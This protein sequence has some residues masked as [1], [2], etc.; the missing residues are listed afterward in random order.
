MITVKL[1][2]GIRKS[3]LSDTVSI[4]KN[5][6]SVSD[7]LDFLQGLVQ[8]NMPV[9]D[10]RNILVAINGADSSVL[11]GNETLLR[12]G[13]VISIIPVV[14]GGSKTRTNFRISNYHV[15]LIRIGKTSADPVRF[16]ESIRT[17]F[18][19]IVIQ[20]IRSKYILSVN[21][22]KRV[23]EVS[24]AANKAGTLLSNKVETDMLMR[25][26]A[27][28]QISDAISKAGLQK[29]GDS[30]LIAIGRESLVNKLVADLNPMVKPM[31]PF[32]KNANFLKKEFKITKKELDCV[33][34]SE[35]LEDL[36]VERS[37]VLLH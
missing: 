24:L 10:T 2:G 5:S 22:A 12:D 3:F 15:E 26:A 21:H 19:T 31:M 29:D 6:M 36:L 17:R 32:P 18:P 11:Q 37:A 13:D 33:M 8:K 14:H 28:K 23:I 25:F 4:E 7:L 34:S 27:S 20:G 30:I 16:L 9:F 35:P 1:L